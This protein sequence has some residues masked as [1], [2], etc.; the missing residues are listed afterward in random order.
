MYR[1]IILILENNPNTKTEPEMKNDST[2]YSG[3]VWALNSSV[4]EK[5]KKELVKIKKLKNLE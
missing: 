4:Y 2:G 1:N 3:M 5:F